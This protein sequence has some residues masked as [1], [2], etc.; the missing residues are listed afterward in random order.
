MKAH[1]CRIKGKENHYFESTSCVA[2]SGCYNKC[3]F[4]AEF[5]PGT[6]FF[7]EL[8]LRRLMTCSVNEKRYAS[9]LNSNFVPYLQARQCFDRIILI[10]H[11][12]SLHIISCV[13]NER[14]D[15]LQKFVSSV[16]I[17][18]MSRLKDPHT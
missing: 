5:M 1:N 17:L 4:T 11:T 2:F 15:F 13:T 12:A 6:L 16:D 3:G 18:I 9:L 8:M 7:N 10:Q 14:R